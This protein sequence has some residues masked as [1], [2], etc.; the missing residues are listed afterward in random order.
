MI[1]SRRR[2]KLKKSTGRNLPISSCVRTPMI[3]QFGGSRLLEGVSVNRNIAAQRGKR[4][5]AV[6]LCLSA[7][8][9]DCVGKNAQ[10]MTQYVVHNAVSR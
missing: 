6:T 3:L 1:C 10:I 4:G 2:F 9:A 7:R 5:R 8:C